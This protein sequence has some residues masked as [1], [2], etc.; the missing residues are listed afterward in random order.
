MSRNTNACPYSCNIF[1]FRWQQIYFWTVGR[2]EGGG[3]L[4]FWKILKDAFSQTFLKCP[5]LDKSG[6]RAVD[7]AETQILISQG[8]FSQLCV[9]HTLKVHFLDFERFFSENFLKCSSWEKSQERVDM[10]GRQILISQGSSI[11]DFAW[12]TNYWPQYI[13]REILFQI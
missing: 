8:N 11:P 4:V 10:E 5:S 6:G 9:S 13:S 7:M 2:V 3:R 1:C 12:Y